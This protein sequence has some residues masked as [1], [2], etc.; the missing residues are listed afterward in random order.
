MMPDLAAFRAGEF[1]L[2]YASKDE[3][4]PECFTCVYLLIEEGTVCFCESFYYYCAYSWPDK[5]TRT[6]PPCLQDS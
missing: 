6:V 4:P 3:L 5:L 2:P 1:S